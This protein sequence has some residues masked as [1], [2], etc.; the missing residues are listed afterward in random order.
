MKP[1]GGHLLPLVVG[2][3]GGVQIHK[4]DRRGEEKRIEKG[5]GVERGREGVA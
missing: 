5:A 4:E 2:G 1:V 3:M